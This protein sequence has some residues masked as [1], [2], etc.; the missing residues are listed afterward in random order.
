MLYCE[1]KWTKKR[2][3]MSM[4]KFLIGLLSL[5]LI[6]LIGYGAGIGYYADRFQ[7]N[8]TFDSVDVSNLTLAQAREKVQNHLDQQVVDIKENGK[9]L[10]QL[11]LKD[12]K[13]E[14]K[15][16][17][18]LNNTYQNQNP[19]YWIMNFF[20]SN[21]HAYSS[22][23]GVTFDD[24]SL[25]QRLADMGINNEQRSVGQPVSIAYSDHQG[26]YLTE[27]TQGDMIDYDKLATLIGKTIA[28]DEHTVELNQAYREVE[29][30]SEIKE[31]AEKVM[32]RINQVIATKITLQIAGEDVVIPEEKIQSWIQFDQSNQLVFDEE[33]IYDY[34]GELNDQ[35]ATYNKSRQFNSTY[36]GPVTVQPGTLGWSIDRESETQAIVNDLQSGQ[37]VTREPVIVGTGYNQAD[38]IGNSYV[39]VSITH[40][41]M[42]IYRDGQLVLETPIVTGQV[43]TDT[44]PGAYS[45]WNK[46]EN[47]NLKGYNP[48]TEKEYDVPV[49]YW[50]PFDDT[51]QGIH[52]ADWQANFGGTTYLERGSLGCVNTP[53]WIMGEVYAAIDIGMPVIVY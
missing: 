52:D 41:H 21:H 46:A 5:F 10:G 35:Y 14:F 23:Q 51:G 40:Q 3:S 25:R 18:A 37:S 2:G 30:D 9:E 12:L 17:T 7:V 4:K 26:Y 36:D 6:L 15:F 27:A 39:E 33:A 50:I 1:E 49:S 8:T 43:G 34:L 32:E 19:N 42:W 47:E 48:R 28:N 22:N 38:D 29:D 31:K 13:S 16:E 45:V 44:I 24:E 53:P 20:N 11:Q